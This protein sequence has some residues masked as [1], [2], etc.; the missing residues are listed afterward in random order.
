M[1]WS[2]GPA[3]PVPT[4]RLTSRESVLGLDEDLA[5]VRAAA[6]GDQS[7]FHV[8]MDRHARRLFRIALSLSRSREDA[9]DIC[10]E[11]FVGAY[12]G[13]ATFDGRST[14]KTWLTKIL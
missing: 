13:L 12:R 1:R 2:F 7:A 11:T 8:V 3:G 9:E 6:A 4:P 5:L 10:Q 14:V